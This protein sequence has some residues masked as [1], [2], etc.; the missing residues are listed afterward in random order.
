MSL[1]P[2]RERITRGVALAPRANHQRCRFSLRERITRGVAS[3]SASESPEA[4][5]LAPRVRETFGDSLLF[6]FGVSLV[7][8][9]EEKQRETRE[10][11]GEASPSPKVT[12]T[13]DFLLIS[14]LEKVLDR[15]DAR[16]VNGGGL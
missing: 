10:T 1:L 12:G 3:R 7:T 6:T 13:N 15:V 11:S 2:L 8:E 14:R 5:L 4:S 9:G 16:V